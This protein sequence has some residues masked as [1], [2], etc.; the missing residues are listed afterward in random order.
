VSMTKR[1]YDALAAILRD[2]HNGLAAANLEFD[3]YTAEDIEEGTPYFK[4]D[5]VWYLFHSLMARFCRYM[6]LTNDRFDARLF[7]SAVYTSAGEELIKSMRNQGTWTSTPTIYWRLV[8][9]ESARRAWGLDTMLRQSDRPMMVLDEIDPP[10]TGKLC[11]HCGAR[12]YSSDYCDP[13]NTDSC[14]ALDE[15]GDTYCSKAGR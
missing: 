12:S 11:C 10:Y 9:D 3:E 1:D 6:E 14:L 2:T 8:L 15:N 13:C 7:A 4:A 5:D